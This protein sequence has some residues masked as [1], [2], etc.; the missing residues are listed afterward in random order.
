[1]TIADVSRVVLVGGST[2]I[3]KVQQILAEWIGTEDKVDKTLN[4]DE[5]IAEGAAHLAA[6][7]MGLSSETIL[8][9]VVPM[10]RGVEVENMRF[11]VIIPKNEPIP[12]RKTKYYTT[13][14]DNQK[15][16]E[17]PIYEGDSSLTQECSSIGKFTFDNIPE[18][19]EM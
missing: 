8:Q 15:Y 17:F 9:D 12:C 19:P 1:M 7:V 14:K 13:T 11:S 10:S 18:M 2:R 5:A 3:P 4:P 16:L 6:S